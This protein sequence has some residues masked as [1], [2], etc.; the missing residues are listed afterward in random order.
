MYFSAL[1]K[2]NPLTFFDY[3]KNL[4]ENIVK[5]NN[6]FAND[7]LKIIPSFHAFLL[8]KHGEFDQIESIFDNE[9]KGNLQLQMIKTYMSMVERLFTLR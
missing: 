6:S 1:L 2:A 9:R 7:D 4:A 8:E 3:K 5:L